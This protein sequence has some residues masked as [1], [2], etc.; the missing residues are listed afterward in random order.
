[1]KFHPAERTIL[2]VTVAL[3]IS[4]FALIW[5]KGIAVDV[6]FFTFS[7]GFSALMILIGQVYRQYRDSERI[8]LT[9]HV[10]GLF[11]GY[12]LFGA[13]F[14]TVLL[15]RPFAPIDPVLVRID[16]WLG[17]SW[18]A[19]CGW[20]AEHPVLNSVLRVVYKL[21]LVQLLVSFI[22][23]GMLLD[24]RRLHGAALAMVVASLITIFCWALFPSGGAAAYWTLDP[25]VSRS[26]R[27]IVGSAYGAE[28]N[29]LFRDGVTDLSAM[30]VT[31]LIGFPSFHTVMALMSLVCVWPYRAY[32]MALLAVTA[33]L[34]P[35]ILVHGGHNLVDVLA[36]TLITAISWP[37]GLR[38]HDAQARVEA[39]STGATSARPSPVV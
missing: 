36:G 15:P 35:A 1:M 30:G 27:P 33:M 3:A 37:L 21:T 28:L 2:L 14:N 31:G 24:R 39:R 20:F 26:V 4:S 5:L 19:I 7:L 9:T 34:L 10:L 23:L 11:I 16:A 12:S 32:R 38:I 18:P 8:A 6:G 22:L 29:R 25:E 17:Y 13:L